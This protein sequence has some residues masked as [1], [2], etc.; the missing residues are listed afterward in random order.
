LYVSTGAIRASCRAAKTT[1]TSSTTRSA[2]SATAASASAAKFT[3]LL[4]DVV[5]TF[6]DFCICHFNC[7][8]CVCELFLL[9]FYCLVWFG[10][11]FFYVLF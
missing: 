5:E 2:S 3:I 9:L 4:D 11:G 1:T 8:V 6:V 7:F 10:F